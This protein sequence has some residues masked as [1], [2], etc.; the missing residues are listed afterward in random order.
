MI[1]GTSEAQLNLSVSE[2]SNSFGQIF[3]YPMFSS[4]QKSAL[5]C[6][7]CVCFHPR[8]KS[9]QAPP[10]PNKSASPGTSL[11]ISPFTKNPAFRGHYSANVRKRMFDTT[12]FRKNG[13]RSTSAFGSA[14]GRGEGTLRAIMEVLKSCQV[15][16]AFR[17]DSLALIASGCKMIS[18]RPGTH[19]FL[20]VCLCVYVCRRA[21]AYMRVAIIEITVTFCD[22]T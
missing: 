7:L 17:N 10:G 16:A 5:K 11:D 1:L 20:K 22:L 9:D 4:H 21:R 13:S 2:R 14:I 19:L 15:F 12:S 6:F 18:S 8:R 3:I